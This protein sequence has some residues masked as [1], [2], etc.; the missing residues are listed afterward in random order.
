M[1]GGDAQTPWRAHEAPV[2]PGVPPS[3]RQ[4]MTREGSYRIAVERVTD[5]AGPDDLRTTD[6]LI[7]LVTEAGATWSGV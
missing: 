5:G 2:T 4:A 3:L 1:S 7:A 6:S